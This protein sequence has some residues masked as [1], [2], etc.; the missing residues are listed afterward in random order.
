[1][2]DQLHAR[3]PRLGLD[4]FQSDRV[5]RPHRLDLHR[6]PVGILGVGLRPADDTHDSHHRLVRHAV[7][8]KGV[9]AR[10]HRLKVKPGGVVAHP[11]PFGRSV[12]NEIVPAIARRFRFH[13]PI[14]H[15]P[16]C[17]ERP[18]YFGFRLKEADSGRFSCRFIHFSQQVPPLIPRVAQLT[19]NR[20]GF[21][22]I[23]RIW[24]PAIESERARGARRRAPGQDGRPQ[25]YC[26]ARRYQRPRRGSTAQGKG[27]E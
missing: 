16:S 12:A 13:Q 4:L 10:L 18:R 24:A 2:S 6:H 14:G 25:R 27:K 23:I 21:A 3:Q 1:L 22:A 20:V 5:E 9:V 8:E 11:V 15:R 7:V 17:S 26:D 19:A